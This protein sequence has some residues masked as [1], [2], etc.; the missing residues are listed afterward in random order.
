MRNDIKALDRR[1]EEPRNHSPS[2]KGIDFRIDGAHMAL[3]YANIT[4]D[5]RRQEA[6][7]TPRYGALHLRY[8]KTQTCNI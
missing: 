5:V 3:S 6:A 7:L 2:C 1:H 8:R 4:R